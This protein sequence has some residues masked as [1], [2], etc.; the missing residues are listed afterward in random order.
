MEGTYVNGHLQEAPISREFKAVIFPEAG[1]ELEFP[2]VIYNAV[3]SQHGEV[4]RTNQ[5]MFYSAEQ[6]VCVIMQYNY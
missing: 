2:G 1:P 5:F 6:Q 3:R 4:V